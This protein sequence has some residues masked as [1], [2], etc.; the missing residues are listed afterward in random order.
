M[1]CDRNGSRGQKE[2]YWCD[3]VFD[4]LVK[5]LVILCCRTVE[6]SWACTQTLLRP[7][8][9]SVS[10]VHIVCLENLFVQFQYTQARRAQRGENRL[11][12]LYI[13]AK[14]QTCSGIE[15]KKW[16]KYALI[17]LACC[18]CHKLLFLVNS[19]QFS[20]V[21]VGNFFLHFLR[22]HFLYTIQRNL[23]TFGGGKIKKRQFFAILQRSI[24]DSG[25]RVV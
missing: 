9:A 21:A 22:H 7:S 16:E 4:L 23:D 13:C 20:V 24:L 19:S 8:S 11:S 10:R 17:K 2:N 5:K 3:S 12:P 18:W 25:R 6:I 14:S 1:T 15:G